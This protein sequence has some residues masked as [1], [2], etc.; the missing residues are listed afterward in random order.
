[1]F[2]YLSLIVL[3]LFYGIYIVKA[4]ILR[5][6]GIT[7]NQMA[8]GNKKDKQFIVECLLQIFTF[9]TAMIAIVS[10]FFEPVMKIIPFQIIGFILGVLGVAVFFLSVCVMSDSWRAGLAE[11][12]ERKLV[13]KGIYKISRNPA[14]LGFYLIYISVLLMCFNWVLLVAT[15]FSIVMFHLQILGEEKFLIRFFGDEYI[16]YKL[17]VNRYFGIKRGGRA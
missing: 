17:R 9:L 8:K 5:K 11:N 7:A 4:I 14:F 12:D 16:E 10:S 2:K 6:K 13:T 1:M 15:L 3:G